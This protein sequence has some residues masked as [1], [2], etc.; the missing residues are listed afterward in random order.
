MR[1]LTGHRWR[2][3]RVITDFESALIA[4]VETELPNSR[5]SGCYFHFT[6]SLWRKI[7]E[8]G[9]VRPYTRHERVRRFVRKVMSIGYLPLPTVRYN[10]QLLIRA[11][12]TVRLIN[13]Y[14]GIRAFIQYFQR[15]YL[16]GHQ[17]PPALWNVHDRTTDNRTN[18]HVEGE[19]C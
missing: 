3:E 4:A 16:D 13:R 7:Q 2:P 6:Q 1:E 10:F 18:N 9:L 15:N 5:A 14:D 11:R 12:A 17:F 8:L 19:G